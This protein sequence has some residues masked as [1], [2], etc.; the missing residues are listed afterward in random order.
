MLGKELKWGK[1]RKS[2]GGRAQDQH[3]PAS[4]SPEFTKTPLREAASLETVK[5]APDEAV[6]GLQPKPRKG[7]FSRRA[8]EKQPGQGR[9]LALVLRMRGH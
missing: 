7:P 2:E 5:P 4:L 8:S 1:E 6:L 3:P 9:L